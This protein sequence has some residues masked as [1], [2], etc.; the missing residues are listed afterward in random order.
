MKIIEVVNHLFYITEVIIQT[1]LLIYFMA[2]IFNINITYLSRIL[3]ELFYYI[4]FFSEILIT[5]HVYI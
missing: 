4:L 5:M 1:Y 2:L 3:V